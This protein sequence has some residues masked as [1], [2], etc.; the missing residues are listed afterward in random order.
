MVANDLINVRDDKNPHS[1]SWYVDS[2]CI[3]SGMCVFILCIC[4]CVSLSLWYTF[5]TENEIEEEKNDALVLH[6]LAAA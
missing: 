2:R 6:S 1:H 3:T 5:V 4:V